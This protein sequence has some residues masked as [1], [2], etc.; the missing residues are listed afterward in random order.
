MKRLSNNAWFLNQA[1]IAVFKNVQ[2]PGRKKKAA[3]AAKVK[4][5]VDTVDTSEHKSEASLPIF[6]LGVEAGRDSFL[7]AE[8]MLTDIKEWDNTRSIFV[9]WV[10]ASPKKVVGSVLR[11]YD[12]L[13]ALGV[14]R[15]AAYLKASTP[16]TQTELDSA[17]AVAAKEFGEESDTYKY[18]LSEQFKGVGNDDISASRFYDVRVIVADAMDMDGTAIM[19][20]AGTKTTYTDK[21]IGAKVDE[22]GAFILKG[23]VIVTGDEELIRDLGYTGKFGDG[24]IIAGPDTVKRFGDHSAWTEVVIP[25]VYDVAGQFCGIKDSFS[26]SRQAIVNLERPEMVSRIIGKATS[27]KVRRAGLTKMIMSNGFWSRA[28]GVSTSFV[29]AKVEF[30]DGEPVVMVPKSQYL[31]GLKEMGITDD[32]MD[33]LVL[34]TIILRAPSDGGVV[35]ARVVPWDYDFIGAHGI[36]GALGGDYDGDIYYFLWDKDIPAEAI[37]PSFEHDKNVKKGKVNV[38]DGIKVLSEWLHIDQLELLVNVPGHVKEA[39]YAELLRATGENIGTIMNMAA[40]VSYAENT[41]NGTDMTFEKMSP[42]WWNVVH[43][44]IH[45]QK[46]PASQLYINGLAELNLVRGQIKSIRTRLDEAVDADTKSHWSNKYRKILKAKNMLKGI[47]KADATM[48]GAYHAWDNLVATYYNNMAKEFHYIP[49]NAQDRGI[50][51]II[52]AM[53]LILMNLWGN[54]SIDNADDIAPLKRAQGLMNL[55][56]SD[57]SDRVKA[58][59]LF[60]DCLDTG[61]RSAWA[62]YMTR[63]GDVVHM[64]DDDKVLIRKLRTI[65]FI[66]INATTAEM[67]YFLALTAFGDVFSYVTPGGS[68]IFHSIYYRAEENGIRSYIGKLGLNQVFRAILAQK[69]IDLEM[70]TSIGTGEFDVYA[71]EHISVRKFNGFIGANGKVCSYLNQMDV[72]VPTGAV[73]TVYRTVLTYPRLKFKV[74]AHLADD[75]AKYLVG[76]SF[77]EGVEFVGYPDNDP[78]NDNDPDKP[79][80]YAGIGARNTPRSILDKMEAMGRRM[81]ASGYVLRSGHAFGADRAFEK[82][83]NGNAEICLPWPGYGVN[84]YKGDPGMEIQG[85]YLGLDPLEGWQFMKQ[86]NIVSEDFNP[87][88]SIKKLHGRNFWIITGGYHNGSPVSPVDQV[89]Y[90]STGGGGTKVALDIATYFG[91]PVNKIN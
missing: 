14:N 63:K 24:D 12:W 8:R 67:T 71:E 54:S 48:G 3:S 47:S 19:F 38:D 56:T 78:D 10:Y 76:F 79:R 2:G 15:L 51:N 58:W 20:K 32:T 69:D 44:A 62:K 27:D 49:G 52:E 7:L 4:I 17:I 18:L 88:E 30:Y 55:T 42:K 36:D 6:M 73:K 64:S 65:A 37:Y 1:L 28:V 80:Y 86:L 31:K 68:G 45:A 34:R 16:V 21:F 77:P 75:L 11:T 29:E 61:Y 87:S 5:S 43:G 91:I 41:E 22:H 53:G 9:P 26:L 50:L 33:G 70:V 40:L 46:K 66:I 35:I 60:L 81:C 82:G 13:D 72:G 23:M 89:L 90:W 84:P 83:A 74:W 39:Y 57:R 59:E 85:V 25:V